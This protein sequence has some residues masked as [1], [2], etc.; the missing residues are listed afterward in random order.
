MSAAVL[1]WTW[2]WGEAKC[3]VHS[4][5]LPHYTLAKTNLSVGQNHLEGFF[6]Q[7]VEL[8]SQSSWF[9]RS[10][11]WTSVCISNNFLGD[12]HAA[13]PC[14]IYIG[15]CVFFSLRK[16]LWLDDFHLWN[17]L[18]W[19]FIVR[20]LLRPN[21]HC[22]KLCKNKRCRHPD[23]PARVVLGNLLSHGSVSLTHV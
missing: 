18:N 17:Q 10:G 7:T 5:F 16:S 20:Y 1:A 6:S 22:Y 11:L 13:S 21:K 15:A 23:F 9:N 3:T 4:E 2:F 19:I 14:F 8:R 12:T